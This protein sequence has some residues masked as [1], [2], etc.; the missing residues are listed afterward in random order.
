M[1]SPLHGVRTVCGVAPRATLIG[2]SISDRHA[3]TFCGGESPDQRL[4]IMLKTERVRVL[5]SQASLLLPR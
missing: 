4:G 2:G 5:S 1:A 3:E